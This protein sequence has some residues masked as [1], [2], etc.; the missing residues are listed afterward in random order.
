M[1]CTSKILKKFISMSQSIYGCFAAENQNHSPMAMQFLNI[2]WL[3]TYFGQ[4]KHYIITTMDEEKKRFMFLTILF[5]SLILIYCMYILLALP[6]I[7]ASIHVHCILC[8][9]TLKK[10]K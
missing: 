6:C 9:P 10:T 2:F 4:E 7:L 3:L 5:Y 8:V 1:R